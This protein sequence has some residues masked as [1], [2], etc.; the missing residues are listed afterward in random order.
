MGIC[1]I[2]L[3]TV[4]I[5]SSRNMP[6]SEI[7][8][9]LFSPTIQF[10]AARSLKDRNCKAF[11]YRSDCAGLC[12]CTHHCHLPVYTVFT[13]KVHHPSCCILAHLDEL[14]LGLFLPMLLQ[15]C[16][17]IPTYDQQCNTHTVLADIIITI[18][19]IIIIIIIVIIIIHHHHWHKVKLLKAHANGPCLAHIPWQSSEA[20]S[21]LQY[22]WSA[23]CWCDC[24]ASVCALLARTSSWH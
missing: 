4:Y 3:E 1:W 15:E 21:V 17:E 23:L 11:H 7:F 5:S 14:L 16:K 2:P 10:L 18:I 24:T 22:Q 6:K 9:L 20:A 19:I 8:T 12:P 13:L